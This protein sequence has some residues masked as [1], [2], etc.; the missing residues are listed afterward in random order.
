MF[1]KLLKNDLKAQW[2]FV[3]T[4]YLCAFIVAAVAEG[5][6]L[7]SKKVSFFSYFYLTYGDMVNVFEELEKQQQLKKQAQQ[8]SG[9]YGSGM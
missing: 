4:I 8:T 7:F 3:S 9:G 5:F 2:H 1:G 6:A